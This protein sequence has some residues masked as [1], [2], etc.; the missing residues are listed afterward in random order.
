MANNVEAQTPAGASPTVIADASRTPATAPQASGDQLRAENVELRNRLSALESAARPPTTGLT[1]TTENWGRRLKDRMTLFARGQNTRDEVGP[2]RRD[3]LS[4][5]GVGFFTAAASAGTSLAEAPVAVVP[6]VSAASLL[7]DMGARVI[8]GDRAGRNIAHTLTRKGDGIFSRFHDFL[9]RPSRSL[10]QRF[11]EG[12]DVDKVLNYAAPDGEAKLQRLSDGRLTSLLNKAIGLEGVANDIQDSTVNPEDWGRYSSVYRKIR[13]A[14]DMSSKFFQELVNRR[15]DDKAAYAA[16]LESQI[17]SA[18]D[19]MDRKMYIKAALGKSIGMIWPAALS[20]AAF[21]ALMGKTSAIW[22]KGLHD[23]TQAV[24]TAAHNF[25]QAAGT[26]FDR[27]THWAWD[28]GG[29]IAVGTGNIIEHTIDAAGDALGQVGDLFNK[30][31]PGPYP[32][33]SGFPDTVNQAQYDAVA[34]DGIEMGKRVEEIYRTNP[35]L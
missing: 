30:T 22:S 13:A 32:W 8:F 26:A 33:E 9:M 34:Q 5:A 10:V 35:G 27:F 2:N 25:G 7:S 11:V 14:G 17:P 19:N 4:A 6:F 1:S 29:K 20:A 18:Q 23:F 28:V 21:S 31:F 24:G 15:T 16:S 12:G 3:P